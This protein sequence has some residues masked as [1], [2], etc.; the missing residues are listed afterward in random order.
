MG[1][2]GLRLPPAK[3]ARSISGQTG[4]ASKDEHDRDGGRTEIKEGLPGK[5]GPAF[6]EA[7]TK[8]EQAIQERA[9]EDDP[10]AFNYDKYYEH[11]QQQEQQRRKDRLSTSAQT[12]PKYVNAM[13]EAAR[14]R[15]LEREGARLH[16]NRER[17]RAE[18]GG[19]GE[20]EVFVTS[21]YQKRLDELH[22]RGI[23]TEAD[24]R[25]GGRA[26][27]KPPLHLPAFY[28]N[29]LA[30]KLGPRR[31]HPHRGPRDFRSPRARSRSPET[32]R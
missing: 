11:K 31:E 26:S 13:M 30:S 28:S 19:E 9:L 12:A 10:D 2:F 1:G 29:V 32:G 8:E 4:G 16:A 3:G 25:E 15:Q 6:N 7:P 20:G 22:K 21:S 17:A 14:Q 5:S 23:D 24:R 18:G 27:Q